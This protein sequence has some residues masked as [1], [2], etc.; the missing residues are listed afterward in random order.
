M[1]Y[2]ELHTRSAFSFLRGA[3]TPE[4]LAEKAA[5]LGLP[6]IALCDRDGVY[7]APRLFGKANEV[8]IKAIVGAELTMDDQTIL[9]VLVESRTG[10][11]NLCQLLTRA[12]LRSE[13]GKARVQWEEL[14]EF[15]KGLVALAGNEGKRGKGEREKVGEWV[16][17]KG[18]QARKSYLPTHTLTDSLSKVQKLE[19][20][21]H[22]F[23]PHHVFVELQR[24][25]LRG[26]E[27][28]IRE[29][30]KLAEHFHLPV[31]ATNGVLHASELERPILDVF[32]CIRNHTHLD[33]AGTLLAQNS[34]RH[35][36]TAAQMIELFR[37]CPEAIEN[38]VLLAERLE[39]T[40]ENLGYEF[41]AYAVPP[42]HT[43]DSFLREQSFIGARK[44]YRHLGE[45]PAKVLQQIETELAL[46]AK[47]KVAGYF[48]IVWDIVEFCREQNI[49]AQGRGSAANS[50]VC[51]CL[52]ITAVDP[53]RFETLF[54]RFLTE[55]RKTSWPDIDIDLPSGDR[56]ERVIQE[57]YQRYG[58]H[59]AAMTANVITFRGR[60]A[61]RE[62]GKALNLSGDVLN[63]FSNLYANGDFPHTLDLASQMEAAGLPKEHPRAA[64]FSR[65]CKA[66]HGLPRHLGQHS[67]GMIICQ[68][69]L[70][71]VMPLENAS[72]P[73]RVVAQWDKDDCEDLGIIKVD[74]LGLGMMSV[75][76]DT[77]ELTQRIGRPIDLAQLPQDDPKT[78]EMMQNADTVGVFQIE[79]R[80]QMATLP[81]MKPKCFYDLVIEVA[82]IRPGPIQ[83]HL[84]H[85]YLDRRSQVAA[86]VDP[87]TF[88]CYHDDLRPVLRRTLG[89]PLFQE[90]MLQIAMVLADFTGAEAEELRRA[91]SFH[92]SQE[93]MQKVEKKLRAAMER[94]RVPQNTIE[95]IVKA[96]GSFALYGFPE[97]HAIS[98]AHLAYASAYLKA[99]RAPEF[100]ASLLNNQ[101]MGFYSSASLVKDGQRHGVKFRP[102]CVMTSEWDCTIEEKGETLTPA[103]SHPMG[104]GVRPDAS[105]IAVTHF[106][107]ER[108]CN[109]PSPIGWE[110]AGVRAHLNSNFEIRLGL[111]VINGLSRSGAERLLTERKK[112]PFSSL[113]DC[114]RRVRL[115]KE[116]WR[117]LAEVGALNCFAAHRRDAL[118]EVEKELRQGDLFEVVDC[119]NI[120]H[121]TSNIELPFTLTPAL[122][123]PMGEGDRTAEAGGCV[124]DENEEQ[125]VP[126]T[127]RRTL[128]KTE[129]PRHSEFGIR[130][131]L[132]NVS[133]PVP[134]A[135]V[136]AS[137][138]A[139]MN[140]AERIRADY[141]AMRLTTGKHPMALL[142]PQLKDVWRAADLPKARNGSRIRIAGNVICR[143]RP[144]T[145]KGFVF[146][147]LEDET[148]ISNAVVTPPMFEANR[149]LITEESFLMIEGRLQHVDNVI[150]V[151]AERI[152]R[153][154]NDSLLASPSYDFH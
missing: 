21:L 13:K 126:N 63:R 54:E 96:V 10:Y 99:H 133:P 114:K 53:L 12:H 109:S 115:N 11:Q 9:P 65:L 86:G 104:E 19:K 8:G 88:S 76:Q 105:E 55:G 107:S 102:V 37:D 1:N 143:Q 94:K 113:D 151:K 71:S 74:F 106:D 57:I 56:R 64:A 7:G 103:L 117:V 73:G 101:P 61:A 52:G 140:Y 116:E 40:L 33:A 131:S 18:N 154:R 39:F 16:S 36:K 31:L 42:G 2:V 80:A 152:E 14:P 89:V 137:P 138:L 134:E 145:A 38:T 148:G 45:I 24:H 4:Q 83:G 130:S 47:L 142:R 50:T 128:E 82:I 92:R 108:V 44:R 95:E 75:L 119:G 136:S 129:N 111:R 32:T 81:R 135:K 84:M 150:H 62:V 132:F 28:G 29:L 125:R 87:E 30:R 91:L 17:G 34:E 20:L 146:I 35:L 97:S 15:A 5:A 46:I 121:S 124:P 122:S 43:M 85:P 49:M 66:M 67:G 153:L 90:Q 27:R 112:A 25:R 149:L 26:E 100:Y 120:Q 58:K 79:S 127:E 69:K 3:S 72:M 48:L 98:F 22:I 23:G 139:P 78:F 41:P 144:G 123:H 147:S 110:R 70:D 51:F 93:R 6:A 77:V 68:G 59:G 118:W 60:S 141:S